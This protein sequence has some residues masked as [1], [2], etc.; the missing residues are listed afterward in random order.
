MAKIRLKLEDLLLCMSNAQDLMSPSLSKHHQ[1]VAYLAIR[2]AE[3]MKL[4][5]EQQKNIFLAGLIHDI[6][7]LSIN[8]KL[9]VIENESVNIND[10]AFKGAKLIEGFYPLQ[11][12]SGIIK[13]HHLPWNCGGGHIYNGEE[14]P[15]ESHI[16]HLADRICT[17]IRSD[18]N[19]I[20]QLP[21]IISIIT[22]NKDTIFLPGAVDAFM[23]LSEKEYIWLDLISSDPVK[24]IQN[25]EPFHV[26]NLEVDDVID[27]ALIFSQIIDFRSKFTARHSA[28]VAKTAEYLAKLMG[29]SPY[30]CKMM[31]IAGYLH[32]L[33]KLAISNEILEN[34]GALSEDEFNIIRTHTYYT[35]HLLEPIE[36]FSTINEWASYHH[37][38]IDGTGYPFHIEGKNLSLGSRVMAVADIFTAITEDRPY[39][40]GMDDNSAKRVLRAMVLDGAIDGKVVGVLLDNYQTIKELRESAQQK[41]TKIYDDFL[42]MK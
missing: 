38:K 10:H 3:Q 26:L 22:Q 5:V 19:V 17:M 35:Y 29:F 18:N 37:E 34:P 15:L 20:T 9:D 1:R 39:R 11:K 36:A 6:G 12:V 33:G 40:Q 16:V 30:E 41:Q 31:L 4:P 28:G 27:L 24:M 23:E 21:G 2:L 13:F 7:A 32:D 25:R 8:E 14:V 42:L